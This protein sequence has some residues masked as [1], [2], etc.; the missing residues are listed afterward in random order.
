M[1]EFTLHFYQNDVYIV[2]KCNQKLKLVGD[3]ELLQWQDVFKAKRKY[4]RFPLS[5]IKLIKDLLTDEYCIT[6]PI[7]QC[8][9]YCDVH[10]S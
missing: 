6:D 10:K 7:F 8:H 2:F 3:G 4:F 9:T 1:W 5:L